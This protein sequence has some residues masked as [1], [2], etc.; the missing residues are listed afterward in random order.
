MNPP[1]TADGSAGSP[2]TASLFEIATPLVSRWRL[3]TGIVSLFAVAAVIVALLLPVQFT[4][5]TTFIA[6]P[7]TDPVRS[8]GAIAGLASQFGFSTPATGSV[9]PDLLVEIVRSRELLEATLASRFATP[10]GADSTTLLTL[11]EIEADTPDE[12]RARGVRALRDRVDATVS[13]R[14][15]L[16]VLDVTLEDP[17]LAADVAN[18]MVALL[19]QFNVERLQSGSQEQRRFV[20][21]RLAEAARELDSAETRLQRFLQANREY[22]SSPLLSFEAA[23]LERQVQVRQSVYLTLSQEYEQAR[24][25]EVRDTPV[26]TIVDVAVPP[27]EKSAPRRKLIVLGAVVVGLLVALPIVFGADYAAYAARRRDAD[28]LAFEGAVDKAR[29]E[30]RSLLTRRSSADQR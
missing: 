1:S 23:R 26:L 9:S 12:E 2:P 4:A 22:R 10:D 15:G 27:D 28:Y 13:R 24:I 6:A 7:D 5:R 14:T 29:S 3:A 16:V 11:L 25:A 20:G 30:V 17:R 21:E 8:L 18:H 19:N